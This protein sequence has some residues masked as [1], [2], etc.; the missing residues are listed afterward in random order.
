MRTYIDSVTKALAPAARRSRLLK[1]QRARG[2]RATFVPV[3]DESLRAL[4]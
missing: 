4:A 3:R 2:R 1:E